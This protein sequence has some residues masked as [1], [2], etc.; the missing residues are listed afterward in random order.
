MNVIQHPKSV[1]NGPLAI[2]AHTLPEYMEAE[3]V[4]D[5]DWLVHSLLNSTIGLCVA[6]RLGL[7]IA[8]LVLAPTNKQFVG[9]TPAVPGLQVKCDEAVFS[10]VYPSIFSNELLIDFLSQNAHRQ[11]ALFGFAANDVGLISTIEGAQRDL[12][13]A[14]IRDSSP[15]FAI[16]GC[17]IKASD[18]A[19]F[20]TI[21][22]FAAVVNL[23]DFVESVAGKHA[24]NAKPAL[25]SGTFVKPETLLYFLNNMRNQAQ[26]LGLTECAGRLEE[27]ARLVTPLPL[28]KGAKTK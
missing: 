18:A 17:S 16:D 22:Y 19:I 1:A 10:Y 21:E 9:R 20:G 4:Y 28:S 13:I 27:A 2:F 23:V 24:L 6:R 3:S 7:P 5:E 26:R 11:L 25:A 15:L 14:V 8:H 12:D